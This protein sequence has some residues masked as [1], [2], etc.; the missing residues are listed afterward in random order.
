MLGYGLDDKIDF[1]E[2]IESDRER[3]AAH[4]RVAIR[5]RQLATGHRTVRRS[6]HVLAA[7]F[8]RGVIDLDGDDL[9]AVAREHLDDAGA[10]GAETHDSDA[11]K[12]SGHDVLLPRT[13]RAR[14][15]H[16]ST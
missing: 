5:L 1:A 13:P 8:E 11:G 16:D 14:V 3:D 10:H 4:Q 6:G 12:L 15:C 2:R 9:D 7:T